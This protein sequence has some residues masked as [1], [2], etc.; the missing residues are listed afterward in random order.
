MSYPEYDMVQLKF[1]DRDG[2]S[3][4]AGFAQFISDLLTNNLLEHDAEIGVAK[5][6]D[7]NGTKG[8]SEKQG[9]VLEIIIKKFGGLECNRCQTK[10]DWVELAEAHDN[11][12]YCSYCANSMDKDKD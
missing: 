11:G 1:A 10:I 2:D 12:G 6:V 4:T 8:L 5:Y 7:D 3:E 9:Q